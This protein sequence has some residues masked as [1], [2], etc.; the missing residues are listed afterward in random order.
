MMVDK[1]SSDC[2]KPAA[3]TQQ[4]N[5]IFILNFSEMFPKYQDKS[6]K[7]RTIYVFDNL[8]QAPPLPLEPVSDGNHRPRRTCSQPEGKNVKRM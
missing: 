3:D 1:P 5:A 7:V 8:C 2:T 4:V 6:K